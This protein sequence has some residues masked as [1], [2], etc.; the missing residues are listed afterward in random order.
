MSTKIHKYYNC[1]I[2]NCSHKIELE[3]NLAENREFYP[4]THVILHKLQNNEN[5]N[6]AGI[7]ILTT[8]YLDVDLNVRGVDAIKL[9]TSEIISI[10][11]ANEI[12][13]KLM[14]YIENLQQDYNQLQDQ[15]NQLLD[16]NKEE[17]AD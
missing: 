9:N 12:I 10:E 16:Q 11:D 2:C 1:P 5:L 8:L 15:Y 6:E 4:F 13:S 17:K 7:D 14:N 3:K